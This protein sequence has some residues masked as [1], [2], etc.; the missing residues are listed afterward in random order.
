MYTSAFKIRKVQISERVQRLGWN[1]TI[2]RSEVTQWTRF[3][4]TVRWMNMSSFQTTGCHDRQLQGKHRHGSPMGHWKPLRSLRIR[5]LQDNDCRIYSFTVRAWNKRLGSLTTF[6][7]SSGNITSRI[8]S[9]WFRK[10]VIGFFWILFIQ[11]IDGCCSYNSLVPCK[12]KTPSLAR[13]R[14]RWK[15]PFLRSLLK[16]SVWSV[17]TFKS[18]NVGFFYCVLMFIIIN[19]IFLQIIIC[20]RLFQ[21]HEITVGKPKRQPS[22]RTDPLHEPESLWWHHSPWRSKITLRVTGL[23]SYDIL[24]NSTH[25]KCMCCT[26]GLSRA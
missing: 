15:D 9:G 26:T 16:V 21:L 17:K 19:V 20:F 8:H 12:L 7:T 13:T 3:Q 11:V 1:F 5:H 10:H 4:R 18:F 25:Q 6:F 22:P 23:W 24:Q 14:S 2:G